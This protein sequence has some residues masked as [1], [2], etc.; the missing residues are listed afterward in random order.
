MLRA[1][2]NNLIFWKS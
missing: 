2:G 1:G